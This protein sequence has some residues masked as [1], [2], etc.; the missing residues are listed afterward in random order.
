[1]KLKRFALRGLIILLVVV[2]LCMF[3]SET[4]KTITTPKVRITQASQGRLEQKIQLNGQIYFPETV[5]YTIEEAVKSPITV[6]KVYVKP[7]HYVEKGETLFTAKMPSFE[8]EMEK[9][10]KEYNQKGQELIDKDIPNRKLSK[11]SKQNDLYE[12]MLDAQDSLSS[13]MQSARLTALDKGVV[14]VG[15]IDAWEKQLNALTEADA[16]VTKAVQQARAAQ[17]TFEDARTEFFNIYENKKL[18]LKEETFTYIKE[19]N[20]ILAAM[21]ELSDQMAQLTQ[22]YRDLSTLAAPQSGYVVSLGVNEGEAYD[23]SKTAYT[24]SKE[25]SVPKLRADITQ[26]ERTFSDGLKVEISTGD[27]G[28]EKTAVESTATDATLTKYL[29]VTLPEAMADAHSG[30]V[31][32]IIQEEGITLSITYRAKKA[33]TLLPPSCVRGEGDSAY[34]YLVETSYSGFMSQPVR[35]LVKQPVTIIEKS[36]KAVSIQEDLSYRQIADQ[37]DRNLTEGGTVMEYVN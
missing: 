30:W 28:T 18:R 29:Y 2:A 21:E 17:K 37:E 15:D 11:Q 26:Q 9:L 20:A 32:R 23:G 19:R 36:D 25:G 16:G 24:L 10:Q 7:G 8:E 31:R 13:A 34:V 33:T 12:A 6:D 1:M 3:F 14:L 35:K 22:R 27:Y 5:D 4:I